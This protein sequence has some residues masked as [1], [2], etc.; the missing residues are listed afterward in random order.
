MCKLVTDLWASEKEGNMNALGYNTPCAG[1][2]KIT[3]TLKPIAQLQMEG[4]N[5]KPLY[6]DEETEI[7]DW[8]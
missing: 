1:T 8:T 5:K 4:K 2:G 7:T 3:L 6:S